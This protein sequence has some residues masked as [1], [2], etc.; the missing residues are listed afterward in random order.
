MWD[1]AACYPHRHIISPHGT[2]HCVIQAAILCHLTV[3]S[4]NSYLF[5]NHFNCDYKEEKEEEEEEEEEGH[6]CIML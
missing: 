2:Q 5:L 1:I 6:L 3:T 4:T